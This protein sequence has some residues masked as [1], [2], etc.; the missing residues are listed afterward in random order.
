MDA[1]GRS[2]AP[3]GAPWGVGNRTPEAVMGKAE[4]A[5]RERHVR[6]SEKPGNDKERAKRLAKVAAL[7]KSLQKDYGD[8]AAM[9]LDDKAETDL[10]GGFIPSGFP[11]IDDVLTG[12]IDEN[13]MTIKGTGQ[14]WPKGR[15]VEVYGP[16]S[17][18]K[19]TLALATIAAAQK[20]GEICAFVDVEHALDTV[21][22]KTLG[23]HVD[24]MLISQPDTAEQALN[25]VEDLVGKKVGVVVVD[26][27][28]ALVP[29]KERDG[30]M[31]D[32]HMGLQGRLMSQA[33]RKLNSRIKGDGSLLIFI[34]QTR[35]KVGVVFGNPETTTGGKALKFYASIRAE[36]KQERKLTTK[37]GGEGAVIGS[38]SR[39]FTAKNKV[40]APFREVAFDIMYGRG[41]MV[42]DRAQVKAERAAFK[43]RFKKKP[44]K[45]KGQK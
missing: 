44:K 16:E 25:I 5:L 13:G 31:G 29:E 45:K 14:G 21:Y 2:G 30:G 38:R 32:E 22:A 40:A 1:F 39:L 9:L 8:G 28:A 17:Q 35:M 15:I 18:G 7:A 11:E 42:P 24:E 26:S 6:G 4:Q 12:A 23:V 27:V 43:E 37:A 20:A 33:L 10:S 36:V 3:K 19:T 41:I 34:N